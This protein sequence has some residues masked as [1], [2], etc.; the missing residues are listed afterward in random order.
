VT[1]AGGTA[2]ILVPAPPAP[3]IPVSTPVPVAPAPPVAT[4]EPPFETTT[5][6]GSLTARISSVGRRAAGALAPRQTRTVVRGTRWRLSGTVTGA[7]SGRV[8]L[9]VWKRHGSRWTAVRRASAA[10][11][12]R[13]TFAAKIVSLP[14]GVYRVRGSF[15]GTGT[16][17]PSHSVYRGFHA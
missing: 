7:V 11:H 16:A 14:R 6:S 15:L 13:G 12:K 4:V 10:V 9:V 2:A 1:L 17:R 8:R 5:P 3:P